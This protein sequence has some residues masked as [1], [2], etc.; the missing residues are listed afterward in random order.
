MQNS[1]ALPLL[2]EV[3]TPVLLDPLAGVASGAHG[4]QVGIIFRVPAY[5]SV[6]VPHPKC[7]H[8][9][10]ETFEHGRPRESHS[11]R[12]INEG[13]GRF[14][15]SRC[16]GMAGRRSRD[17]RRGWREASGEVRTSPYTAKVIRVNVDA[18]SVITRVECYAVSNVSIDMVCQSDGAH[19]APK[20]MG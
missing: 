12:A 18:L 13:A 1:P 17:R 5:V 9:T 11:P 20:S 7:E 19:A 8:Q 2:L 16:T 10:Q 4:G 3:V 6:L 15:G 14:A